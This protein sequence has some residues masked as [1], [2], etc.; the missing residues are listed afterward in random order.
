MEDT[1]NTGCNADPPIL[2]PINWANNE[3]GE[4]WLCG[5]SGD[6]NFFGFNYRD[7]DWFSAIALG[8]EMTFTVQSAYTV[9]VAKLTLPE[10]PYEID[11]FDVTSCGVPVSFTF[12]T[13]PGEEIWLVVAAGNVYGPVGEFDYFATLSGHVWDPPVAS[14]E[15]SWGG[16]KALF[17]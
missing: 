14:E 10:C 5:R 11:L 9:Q 17:R 2:Q 6:F 1:Y 16:V 13:T 15:M 3:A 12:P 7:T 4:A 8:D